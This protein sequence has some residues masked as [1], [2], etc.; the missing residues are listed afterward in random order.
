MQTGSPRAQRASSEAAVESQRPPRASADGATPGGSTGASA[1][2]PSALLPSLTLPKGGG[3]IHGIGEK[4][5]ANPVSGT[6]ALTVPI[7]TSPARSGFGPQLALAYDSGAGNGPFGF[8]WSLSVPRIARKTDKGLPQYVD[9]EESDVFLLSGAEDLVPVLAANGEREADTTT[10]PGFTIHRYLPRTEGLFAR[11]ER[12]TELATGDVH[13]RSI[14]RDNVTN[15]YGRDNHARCFDPAEGETAHPQRIFEWLLCESYDDKGNA[16]VYEYAAEDD[17]RV[18]RMRASEQNRQR[19]AQRYLK[20]V[21][22]G[23]RVSR[24]VQPDLTTAEWL[25]EVVLDYDEDHYRDLPLDPGLPA[26]QQHRFASVS[27]VSSGDWQARPDPF[28]TYRAGFEQRSY[29]RCA[30]ILMFHNFAELG[31]EPCLVRSTEIDYADLDLG[32][33]VTVDAEQAHQGSTRYASFV[34]RFVQSGYVRVAGAPVEVEGELRYVRYLKR[35]L[36]PL[37]L[38]YSRPAVQNR[39]QRLALGDD[40]Q[41]PMGVDGRDYQ[42]VDLDGEGLSGILTKQGGAWQYRSNLGDGEFGASQAL[43]TQPALF[44][45]TA[46]GEQLL[47]LSGDGQLDV[48]GF[49]DGAAGFYERTPDRAWED[50]RAFRSLPKIR[51]NDNNTRFVDLTGDGHADVLFSDYEFFTWYPSLKEEGFGPANQVRQAR[52][53]EQGP[54]LVFADGTESIYLADMSGDGLTDIVRIRNGQI[55]YWPNLG[56]GRFAAKVTMDNP[57]W[58]ER[59][60]LFDQA[61]VRLADIDGSGT[62]DLIYL[63]REGPRLYFNQSGNGW[64]DARPL[65]GLPALDP[66]SAV[67]T[68]DLLGNGTA[69]LVWSSSLPADAKR[70]VRFVDLM[71][72]QKPHLLISS[73]NQLGAR[74]RV[75]Y[76]SSTKFYLADQRAGTPWITR[77]PFPVHVVERVVTDD[78]ISGNRFVT[79]YSYHHGY[80]DGVE[81]E[82]RGFGRVD[83]QDTEEFASF[84]ND[85]APEP[86]TNADAASHVPPVL[87]KTWFHTGVC[88]DRDHVS[89]FFAGL[90]DARDVGEYYRPAGLT[91][92]QARA[93]LLP[94]TVLPAGLSPAEEREACRSLRGMMLRQE[95]YALDGSD[96]ASVPYNVVEQ[97]FTVRR[98]QP[99]G[100]NRHGVFFSFPREAVNTHYERNPADPRVQHALTLEVDAFGNVLRSLAVGYGRRTPASNPD[101]TAE[102]R[103]KQSNLLLTYTESAYTQ[104][105]LTG[106]ALATHHRTPLPAEAKTY[107]LSGFSPDGERFSFEQWSEGDFA[108]IASAAEI[109][110]ESAATPSVRQK[111]LIER[112]RTLYRKDDLTGFSVLGKV[113]ALALPGETYKLALTGSL[114]ASVFTRKQTGQP[115]EAL[116]PTP[117]TLLEG[118]GAD[119]G[120]YVAWDG[121][122]WI[123]S[124]RVF[125]DAA[126]NIANPALTASAERT[127][128]NQ[129][130]FTPRKVADPFQNTS[131]VDYDAYDSLVTTVTDAAGNAISAANDYRVLQPRQVIDPNGNRSAAAFDALGFVV[132][133]AL[134]GKENQPAGDL[135]EGFTSE[136]TLSALQAF[137]AD[138]FS[139]ASVLLGRATQRTIYDFDR[140]RRAAEPPLHAMLIRETHYEPA[141]DNQTRIQVGFTFSDGFGRTLQKKLPAEPGLAYERRAPVPLPGGD[142]RAGELLRDAQGGLVQSQAARRWVSSG[143]TVFNNKGQPVK[144]YEPFFSATHLF[145]AE[146]EVTDTGVSS[147]LF[148][149]PVGRV[150]ATL[151]PNHTYEKVRFDPW[152]HTTFDA[153]D[154]SAPSGTETGDPRTDPDIAGYVATYFEN[155]PPTWKTWYAQRIDNALGEAERT[156]AQQSAAHA[157][158]PSSQ[159]LDVLGRTILTLAHNKVVCPGHVLDGSEGRFATRALLDIEGNQ[160]AVSDALGRTVVRYDYDL[161]GNRIHESSMEAGER[162][163]L[164]DASGRPIRGWDSRRFLRRMAYDGL[165]RPTHL[166]VTEN[167]VERLA[168]RSVYGESQGASQNHRG[169]VFQRFD[170]A[171]VVTHVAYDFK[172]N[173]L[174]QRR[175]VLPN[176][177]VAVDWGQNPA[178][179]DGSYTSSTTYDAMNRAVS[180]TSPDASEYRSTLNE[181][182]LLDRVDVQL[183]GA[184]ALTAFVSNVDYNA[185]AQRERIAYANGAVTSY[186]YDPLT[187]RLM[188]L[189]TVRPASS[190]ATA[191]QILRDS[192]V[193]Q[194]LRYTYDAVGNPARIEDTALQTVL[195]GGQSIEPVATYTYDALYRLVEARG[196]EHIAQTAF[197]FAPAD[198]NQRDAPFAGARVNP[199]D[200]QALCTFVERYAYDAVGNFQ[201]QVHRANGA[202]W[203]R[204]YEYLEAS[205]LEPNKPNNRLSRTTFGD[206]PS[207]IES[208]SHDLHGNITAMPHLSAMQWSF[209][210]ELQ[211]VDLG[212]GGKGYYVY[213]GSGQRL[214][215]V[216]DSQTGVRRKERLYLGN[217]ELYR[218]YAANGTSVDLER[219]SLHVMDD[220]QRIALAETQTIASG[221]TVPSPTTLQRYQLSNHL[222][223]ASLELDTASA[224][225]T[226]EEYHPYGT[227]SFQAGRTAAEL[228]LKRYRYTG[229]ERDE[230]SGFN[231]HGARYYACWLGRWTTVDP[232]GVDA[233][234]NAYQY[235]IGNPIRLFDPDGRD[236]RDSLSWTQQAALWVDD[237]VQ[238]SAVARGVV[239]NLEK[240]GEALMKAPAALAEQYQQ[241]GLLGIGAAVA[242]G[243]VH[244]V[245]DTAD[246]AADVGYY[247][248]QA[249]FE[250]DEAAKEKVASRA[251][252]IVLNIA[253]IVTL[254]DGAGAAKNA[255]VGGSK[256]VVAGGRSVINTIKDAAAAASGGGLATAEGLVVSGGK[257]IASAGSGATSAA[258]ILNDAA[259]GSV[260]MM[261]QAGKN[262]GRGPKPKLREYDHHIATDKNRLS[263]ARGGPWT[264]RFEEFFRGAGLDISKA[265]ANRVRIRGHRGPHPV[266]YHQYVYDQLRQAT[267]GLKPGTSAYH[268]AVVSTLDYIAGQARTRGTLVNKWLTKK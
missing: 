74:T 95:V 267:K 268:D 86:P 114:L 100:A 4:F 254:V 39:V 45:R 48:V 90:I 91:D 171:G 49:A 173:L 141:R 180:M 130:F 94:D 155:Q 64:S 7:A 169:Q 85:G 237:R 128:A 251:L 178:A 12:W 196:R 111:R 190:D 34:R 244:L 121:G 262:A 233:G 214:R 170:G 92:G 147:V 242:K 146:A 239:G 98:V 99:L 118:K 28:S 120:G 168:E 145:E 5:A 1:N 2:S 235:V 29:R 265:T 187:F 123:P 106:A 167:N 261:S 56:Y 21:R 183:R 133:T 109:P 19:A 255:V 33:P 22:Y 71:G 186:E 66:L 148:Y 202:G 13:W 219:Q 151:H 51:W 177:R 176:Y 20:R 225:I 87:T 243:A 41:L 122:W 88:A 35:S 185:K 138:P 105:D 127:S 32:Q 264:P 11:I 27:A 259:K 198:G 232:K 52:D 24:L 93:Q 77:L 258:E 222:G 181:A 78:Q 50:F 132:A 101:L 260:L 199:N 256:A 69:C 192:G 207:R 18:N 57:P 162:W 205:Q 163:M 250:G 63:H 68:V 218:E 150:V 62:T 97:N 156:A 165:R 84:S 37:E 60:D 70:P 248:A 226:Y 191:S 61:R 9:A 43:R 160:R 119:Q 96:R 54:R 195:R 144:Q 108:L 17:Q 189:R 142:L 228:N 42:W 136:L 131:L 117:D 249:Y 238:E 65:P 203:T 149:D 16:I 89:D 234:I 266:E 26:D 140:F 76:A 31:A 153:N 104:N 175:D 124:G 126:A 212:G 236:W 102:D 166:Y 246:A 257:A 174:Q 152:Q 216:I 172:G 241:G 14:T 204:N 23:N 253:D 263:S 129:H 215:K 229:K 231:Y 46:S 201:S 194:D 112:V 240:R 40:T 211:Q 113:E 107:E 59:G 158:T 15:L 209:K 210:D 73:T 36:P 135:L 227:T 143:R 188:R 110:Y 125:Y 10:S 154:T 139:Q 8:G 30:R 116:L 47:D 80:Y 193:L 223:S 58:F 197:D 221:A 79:R 25:F 72:G 53:E 82:F 213:D 3:A 206:G 220:R 247:G 83:Q 184:S 208:Y 137:I 164:S 159:H 38:E 6:G 103:A 44:A 55:C 157:N 161:L 179:N 245:K 230:E 115:D 224:L 200:L 252:D 75:E 134:M 182:N 81:R 217:F 67:S